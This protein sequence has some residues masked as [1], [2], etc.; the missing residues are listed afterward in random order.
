M[1]QA[2]ASAP[3][4]P[5]ERWR[6]DQLQRALAGVL[7]DASLTTQ[8]APLELSAPSDPPVLAAAEVVEDG[9]LRAHAPGAGDEPPFV[10][11][12][13]GTQRS[14]LVGHAP[15]GVPIV[16]GT[17]AAV[18]REWRDGH[19]RTWRHARQQRLYA[20]R[21]AMPPSAWGAIE[22]LRLP[23]VDTSAD[24]PSL[25][26]AHPAAMRDAALERIQRDREQEEQQVAH[27]WCS[28]RDEALYVDG[29]LRGSVVLA[30][31]S[32]PVGVIK[33]HRTLYGDRAA[34]RVVFELRA[35]ER[36]SVFVVASP[37]RVPVASW[38]LRL[39]DPAGH[40]PL[41][42]LVRVEVR[43]EAGASRAAIMRRADAVSRRILGER[44][45]TAHPDARWDTMVYG[46]RDCEA[47]LKAMP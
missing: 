35:G 33:S 32:Q 24:D 46:I 45:P 37:S 17:V 22:A 9:V 27:A 5:A 38:Y 2:P 25:T 43:H 19:A 23:V 8:G 7:P 6:L 34:R 12:L 20:P 39:R 40:D 3:P 47:F 1:I 16:S 26:D 30:R 41:W 29:G 10:A 4:A 13:D 11:F 44:M 31:A 28:E 42:G 15:D 14:D 21:A 36:S 18:V